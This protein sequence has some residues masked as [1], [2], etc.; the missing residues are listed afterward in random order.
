[1]GYHPTVETVEKEYMQKCLNELKITKSEL[2]TLMEIR[3]YYE[4]MEDTGMSDRF[5]DHTIEKFE[6]MFFE[7]ENAWDGFEC[8]F[9]EKKK[10]RRYM[11]EE[12]PNCWDLKTFSMNFWD[13]FFDYWTCGNNKRKSEE[14]FT[15]SKSFLKLTEEWNE[16]DKDID[17]LIFRYLSPDKLSQLKRISCDYDSE[18]LSKLEH[19]GQS[20]YLVIFA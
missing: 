4:E 6:Q 15:R 20:R 12:Y 14:L 16:D 17:F 10:G 5:T 18:M 9:K 13:F 7:N 19:E 1:M 2:Y 11:Y 3:F 8:Y